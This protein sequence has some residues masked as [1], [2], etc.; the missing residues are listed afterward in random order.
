MANIQGYNLV[1]HRIP[2]LETHPPTLVRYIHRTHGK[3]ALSDIVEILVKNSSSKN[4]IFSDMSGH[5]KSIYC[6]SVAILVRVA[7]SVGIHSQKW[8][9]LRQSFLNRENARVRIESPMMMDISDDLNEQIEL[10]DHES[11]RDVALDS[12]T[13]SNVLLYHLDDV[14]DVDLTSD[15]D[16][17][18][19]NQAQKLAHQENDNI[20]HFYV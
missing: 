13:D 14:G 6:A 1:Y 2:V 16:T 5:N 7:A 18:E 17:E 3:E 12:A 9:Q 11:M 19:F 8:K 15:V 20:H 4:I 10:D